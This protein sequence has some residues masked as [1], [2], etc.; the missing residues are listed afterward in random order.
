MGQRSLIENPVQEDDA[1]FSLI[2]YSHGESMGTVNIYTA[3]K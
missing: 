1:W 3:L 2:L